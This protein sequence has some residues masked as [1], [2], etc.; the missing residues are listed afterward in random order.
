MVF[1]RLANVIRGQI[2]HV[3]YLK[4]KDSQRLENAHKNK[5]LHFSF[6]IGMARKFP[7]LQQ[8]YYM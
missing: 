5:N 6:A 1:I 8:R 2:I 3:Q 4:V 7:E